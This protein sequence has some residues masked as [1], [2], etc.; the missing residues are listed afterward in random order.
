MKI[1]LII[2]TLCLIACGSRSASD[3]ENPRAYMPQCLTIQPDI[4]QSDLYDATRVGFAQSGFAIA[5][6]DPRRN[7]IRTDR[8]R[9]SVYGCDFTVGW[10]AE[11]YENTV[12]LHVH[13]STKNS[14]PAFCFRCAELWEQ[15]AQEILVR[16]RE[17]ALLNVEE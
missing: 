14:A 5:E 10:T 4:S 16:I 11:I 6:E 8:D 15:I 3:I 12:C 17:E 13:W 2:M 7:T 9:M 1:F